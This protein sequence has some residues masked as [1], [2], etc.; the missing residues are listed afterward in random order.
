MKGR[1]LSKEHKRKISKIHK[2][3]IISQETKRKMSE[4]HKGHVVT[5][6][7]RRKISTTRRMK[8]EMKMYYFTANEHY[9]YGI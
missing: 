8:I 2:G 3:K 5:L 4:A 1:Q 6:E 9:G 7:T